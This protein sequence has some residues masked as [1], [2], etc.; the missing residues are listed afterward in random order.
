MSTVCKC[1]LLVEPD[2]SIDEGWLCSCSPPNIPGS[3]TLVELDATQKGLLARGSKWEDG[4]D[5]YTWSFVTDD[6]VYHEEPA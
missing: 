4:A 2:G 1:V 5:K 6:L 3:Q